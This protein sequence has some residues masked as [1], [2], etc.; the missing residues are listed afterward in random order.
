MFDY[1]N[2]RMNMVS[3]AVKTNQEWLQKLKKHI[4][5]M[6]NPK[7]PIYNYKNKLKNALNQ[8]KPILKEMKRQ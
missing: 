8:I 2:V 7:E 3:A 4:N 1:P 5:Q 6:E